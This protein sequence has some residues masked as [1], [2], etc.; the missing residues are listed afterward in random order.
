MIS[1]E[2]LPDYFRA[3]DLYVSCSLS[4]G[5]SVS[6][7]EAMATGLPVVVTEAP[8]NHEWVLTSD[9]GWLAAPGDAGCR[10][11]DSFVPGAN[12]YGESTTHRA[13]SQLECQFRQA[14]RGLRLSRSTIQAS[15]LLKSSNVQATDI[16]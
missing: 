7:F 4:D 10:K 5:S 3:A 1:Q 2:R 16:V 12:G 9:N 8:G 15:R 6:L 14:A 11:D 13:A